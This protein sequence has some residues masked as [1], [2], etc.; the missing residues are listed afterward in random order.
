MN[1]RDKLKDPRWQKKRLEVFESD[2]FTCQY[3]GDNKTELHV[4]HKRYKGEP[5]EADMDDLITA[6]SHC[7]QIEEKFKTDSP[8]TKILKVHKWW[9][10]DKSILRI[11]VLANYPIQGSVDQFNTAIFF[12]D[13]IGNK[14]T[15]LISSTYDDMK[16]IMAE[17]DNHLNPIKN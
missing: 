11:A 9:S 2:N 17:F 13:V 16:S 8:G 14:L 15:F 6:C 7:H 3:C 10:S 12:H 1:Y 5:W 4:H